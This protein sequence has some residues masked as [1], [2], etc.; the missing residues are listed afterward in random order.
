VGSAVVGVELLVPSSL[1]N[2][3]FAST[4]EDSP[5]RQTPAFVASVVVP[6]RPAEPLDRF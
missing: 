1:S 6:E 4:A 2:G 5:P 3:A